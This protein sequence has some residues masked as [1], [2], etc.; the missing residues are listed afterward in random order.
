MK[1]G[2]VLSTMRV[3]VRTP[4]YIQATDRLIHERLKHA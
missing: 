3:T 2:A 1:S 4:G